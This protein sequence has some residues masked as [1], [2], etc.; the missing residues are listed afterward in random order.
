MKPSFNANEYER[1]DDERFTS[2]TT[3]PTVISKRQKQGVA[4]SRRQA[5]TKLVA[6]SQAPA[7]QKKSRKSQIANVM[8]PK[9][10]SRS[11]LKSVTNN[12]ASQ[13]TLNGVGKRG[14]EME[15]IDR[16]DS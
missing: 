5:D 1:F 9:K 13:R 11:I 16:T 14:Q 3:R 6:M 2:T 12:I 8:I 15:N 10:G 7:V 4:A